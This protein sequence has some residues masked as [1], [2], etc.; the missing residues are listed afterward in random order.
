MKLRSPQ[1]GVKIIFSLNFFYVFSYYLIKT[2]KN[3]TFTQGK[4]IFG[5]GTVKKVIKYS[6]GLGI[7]NGFRK[8][9]L[10]LVFLMTLQSIGIGNFK[11]LYRYV[12]CW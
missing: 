7:V 12:G 1:K 10:E 8:L 6:L 2:Q 5:I 11:G 9:L 3:V 4:S